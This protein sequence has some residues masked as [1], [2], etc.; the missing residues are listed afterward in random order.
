MWGKMNNGGQR[1][2]IKKNRGNKW[3]AVGENE[4]F[5]AFSGD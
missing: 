3:F 1:R 4:M 2:K 5:S